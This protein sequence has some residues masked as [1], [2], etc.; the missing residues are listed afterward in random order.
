MGAAL[1]AEAWVEKGGDWS[2]DRR[3]ITTRRGLNEHLA[4]IVARIP[5]EKRHSL[6]RVGVEEPIAIE[7]LIQHYV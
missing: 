6:I 1:E 3:N 5:E 2:S 4:R 7:E